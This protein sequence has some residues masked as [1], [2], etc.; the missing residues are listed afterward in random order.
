M[1]K[2]NPMNKWEDPVNLG[3][4]INSAY[5]E[6]GVYISPDGKT[7]YFS[8][9]GHNSMGGY[10]IFK[11]EKNEVNEWTPPVNLGYP[12]NTPDDELFYS[13]DKG[14]KYAHFSSSRMGSAGGKDI[15]RIFYLGSEKEMVMT[16]EDILIAG[17]GETKKTG[18]FTTPAMF[19]LDTTYILIG[20]VYDSESREGVQAKLDF[21]DVDQSKVIA[22]TLAGDTGDYRA[23][24]PEG[25]AYGVE[26]IAKDYLLFLDVIDLSGKSPQEETII[27]FALQKVVVGAKVVLENIF[28]ES[29]NAVLKTESFHQL[30][31]VVSFMESNASLRMEI[32]GHT[33]NVGSLKTNTSISQKRAEA[34]VAYL[35]Q[36]GIAASRLDAKGY[37]FS[38]P[39]DSNATPEGRAKNRRVEFKILSK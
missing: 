6:E 9:K 3:R 12:V 32:S 36:K 13:L 8:S 25:K 20:K 1:T 4:I 16:Y 35:V 29:G 34:V 23:V 17:A 38:Q 24:L 15:F 18:F 14:G 11:S 33:D 39:I 5:D 26:I 19:S 30:D 10:D 2:K 21:I 22:T 28:F 27:D 31:Q 37:A 7:L